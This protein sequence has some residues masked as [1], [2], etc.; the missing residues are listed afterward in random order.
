MPS[1]TTGG[2]RGYAYTTQVC[3]SVPL[4]GAWNKALGKDHFYTTLPNVHAEL[5]T[6]SGWADVGI[7][8][9]DIPLSSGE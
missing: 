6:V 2:I 4:Y 8:F 1:Y 3:G 5:I 7:V 9:Y